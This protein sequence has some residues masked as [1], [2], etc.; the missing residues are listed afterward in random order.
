[1]ANCQDG[2]CVERAPQSTNIAIGTAVATNFGQAGNKRI[3]PPRSSEI[4]PQLRMEAPNCS[5]TPFR[6]PRSVRHRRR[7]NAFVKS[8]PLAFKSSNE[9]KILGTYL[10]ISA[11]LHYWGMYEECSYKMGLPFKCCIV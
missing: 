8:P 2:S 10:S 5:S 1:M 6:T 7:P 3:A 11:E 4:T 9:D